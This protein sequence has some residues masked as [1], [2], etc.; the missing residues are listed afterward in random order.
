VLQNVLG[1]N[2]QLFTMCPRLVIYTG[3][4]YRIITSTLFHANLM[5]IGMNVLSTSAIGGML[6]QKLGTL[7]L[8]FTIW[9]SMILT[10]SLYLLISCLAHAIFR[11]DQLLYSHAVGFS[12]V[13]FHLSVLETY[14]H[15]SSSS[16]S[17]FGFVSVPPSLYPWVLLVILQFL[18]PN[19]S[20]LGHLCGIL[21]GNAQYFGFLD[22]FCL[23]GETFL[24]D[25]ETRPFL[26]KLT[27]IPGFVPTSQGISG[28]Y[29]GDGGGGPQLLQFVSQSIRD[30]TGYLCKLMRDVFE[31]VAVCIFGRGARL[32]HN[33]RFWDR[34]AWHVD[35]NQTGL[36]LTS[37]LDADEGT[38][39]IGGNRWIDHTTQ[40]AQERERIVS[41]II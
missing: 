3:E 28:Q 32:N 41:R 8:I 25:L 30:V 39:N 33:I 1:L 34:L 7:R 27:T 15:S 12:G 20:F 17:L 6:E 36:S 19:I 37:N 38:T 10:S 2:L 26:R 4:Y 14:L 18:M 22:Y 13:I 16:R 21:V 35:A 24:M 9:W 40:E 11:Y 31:T 29:T 23:M 5:H